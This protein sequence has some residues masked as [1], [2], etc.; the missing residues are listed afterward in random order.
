MAT[1]TVKFT[2]PDQTNPAATLGD[3]VT[4]TVTATLAGD[5]TSR[6]TLTVLILDPACS[7]VWLLMPNPPGGLTCTGANALGLTS[8]TVYCVI[9]VVKITNQAGAITNSGSNTLYVAKA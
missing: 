3:V 7:K 6:T 5:P 8:K 1:L 2:T 4:V 9:A